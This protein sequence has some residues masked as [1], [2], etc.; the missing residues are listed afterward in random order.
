MVYEYCFYPLYVQW[1]R[2][3]MSAIC[4]SPHV[5][6]DGPNPL[7]APSSYQFAPWIP[8]AVTG[9]GGKGRE[10]GPFRGL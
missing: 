1:M 2:V 10:N 8:N 6:A 4:L 3:E 5:R 7:A 9:G